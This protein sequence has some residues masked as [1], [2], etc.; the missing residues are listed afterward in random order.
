MSS[1]R[2]K[3][4]GQASSICVRYTPWPH[5]MSQTSRAALEARKHLAAEEPEEADVVGRE[6]E[7]EHQ[8]GQIEALHAIGVV[9]ELAADLLEIGAGVASGAE[10]RVLAR[11]VLDREIHPRRHG[12]AE[13][14]DVPMTEMQDFPAS[15][16]TVL[17]ELVVLRADQAH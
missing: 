3:A 17:P 8:R 10:K 2:P 9:I 6:H 1:P 16:L 5:P 15:S 12:T 7:R 13:L 4:P 11:Q 14:V